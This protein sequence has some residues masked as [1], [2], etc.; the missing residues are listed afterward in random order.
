MLSLSH[1]ADILGAVFAAIAV[2]CI[3][4]P[5]ASRKITLTLP[6]NRM[7]AIILTA[8]DL[9]WAVWLLWHTPMGFL[10]KFKPLMAMLSPVLFFLIVWLMNELL[11]ARALGGLFVLLPAPILA[12][13]RW[14]DSSLRLVIVVLA[15]VVAIAGMALVLSPYL[16]RKWH[17]FLFRNNAA[18]RIWGCVILIFGGLLL[19]LGLFIY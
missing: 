16:F 7:V 6:R 14:H 13:A 12:V 11:A 10:D 4:V 15:Y 19:F 1:I 9:S 17:E 3:T 18:C 2:P 5:A 8:I